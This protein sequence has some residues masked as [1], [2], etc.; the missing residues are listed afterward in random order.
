MS[1]W[2][3]LAPWW[4]AGPSGHR[5]RWGRVPP[6]GWLGKTCVVGSFWVPCARH[7]PL[8]G[9]PAYL[10]YL[11]AV[12]NSGWTFLRVSLAYLTYLPLGGCPVGAPQVVHE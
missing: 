6:V 11:V 7:L 4:F 10:R 5:I 12:A 3:Y 2:G 1:A 9:V 8:Q